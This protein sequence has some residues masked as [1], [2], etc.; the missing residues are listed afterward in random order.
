LERTASRKVQ[1]HETEP[2]VQKQILC[3][4]STLSISRLP[5]RS[6]AILEGTRSQPGKLRV[7]HYV[8]HPHGHKVGDAS[9][10]PAPAC[11]HEEG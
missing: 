7:S 9:I 3:T 6:L 2:G 5:H 8:E 1:E 4:R 10:N 11:H